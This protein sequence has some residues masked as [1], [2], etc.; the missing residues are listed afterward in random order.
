MITTT[1]K[2]FLLPLFSQSFFLSTNTGNHF[3]I[4]LIIITVYGD[5]SH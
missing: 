5:Y 1:L 4:I 3:S 2:S